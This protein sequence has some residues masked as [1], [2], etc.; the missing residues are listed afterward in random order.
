VRSY[1]LGTLAKVLLAEGRAAEAAVEIAAS[2]PGVRSYALGTLAKVLL[3]E[4]R[5]AEARAPAEEAMAIVT[6]LGGLEEGEPIV[7]LTHAEVLLAC[8][9]EAG[10]RA[11]LAV[12][13]ER[14]LSRA[15]KISD[16]DRRASLLVSVPEHARTMA[17]ATELGA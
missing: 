7:R 6:S 13:R 5:A 9:D 3:A 8:G 2:I 17:L 15:A 11:A 10:A 4:G 14:L 1:A 12:A 16:P